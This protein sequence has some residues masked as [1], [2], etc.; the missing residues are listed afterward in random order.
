VYIHDEMIDL[1]LP[2]GVEWP[3]PAHRVFAQN[4]LLCNPAVH[5]CET[6]ARAVEEV[7][8]LTHEQA[9]T[10]TLGQLREH[11]PLCAD[12]VDTDRVRNG[13]EPLP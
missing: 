8:A 11:C 10:V 7:L 1:G 9:M 4:L 3:T 12:L 13:E 5:T 2:D 6:L